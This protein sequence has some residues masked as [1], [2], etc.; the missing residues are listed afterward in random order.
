MNEFFRVEKGID[1]HYHVKF[2][3]TLESIS[4]YQDLIHGD[5]M[6]YAVRLMDIDVDMKFPQD[7]EIR[8]D[9]S[10]DGE[11]EEFKNHILALGY[12][13][14]EDA[15][16]FDDMVY[17]NVEDSQMVERYGGANSKEIVKF[18][19]K[20]SREMQNRGYTVS[21]SDHPTPYGHSSYIKVVKSKD[22]VWV[23][24]GARISDHETGEKRKATDEFTTFI[25]DDNLSKR[26][27]IKHLEI[28]DREL[29]KALKASKARRE[30]RN[31]ADDKPK[32]DPKIQKNQ[33]KRGELIHAW[34]MNNHPEYFD[35]ELTKT[36]KGQIK[37]KAKAALKQ[38][39][40]KYP[41]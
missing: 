14:Q 8:V 7:V 38:E 13:D 31:K 20:V 26:E 30:E 2:E 35:S 1:M 21:H 40:S 25:Y 9:F 5:L 27:I 18:A 19:Q 4:D 39:L 22:N 32:V 41:V 24:K 34:I 29:E 17:L 33:K 15:D 36:K 28:D 37:T 3:V 23:S 6:G 10:N 16:N 11:I 12:I